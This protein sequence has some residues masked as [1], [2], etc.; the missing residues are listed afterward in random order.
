M[1]QRQYGIAMPM[2]FQYN[3]F[4]L[5][6][7]SSFCGYVYQKDD[8]SFVFA[9]DEYRLLWL[10]PWWIE[11]GFRHNDKK[12]LSNRLKRDRVFVGVQ[13]REVPV[14]SFISTILYPIIKTLLSI[15]TLLRGSC[16][17]VCP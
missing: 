13:L 17:V 9:I 12:G 5:L 10:C 1:Y 11:W 4:S 3:S 15:S 16:S 7:V 2:V 14:R 8:Y 6:G